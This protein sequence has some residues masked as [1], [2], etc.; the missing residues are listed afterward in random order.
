MSS[1][2]IAPLCYLLFAICYLI[3]FAGCAKIDKR[4]IFDRAGRKLIIDRPIN[5]IVS[6]AP[7]N[8][9]II[10]DLGLGHKLVAT[11][12]YS[13]NV[14]GIPGSIVLLDFSYP[15]A[16]VIISLQPDIIF[17][18]GHNTTV[19]GDDPFRLLRELGIP[20]AYIS[21]SN[22]IKGIYED[23]RFIADV[24]QVRQ[25]G[26][27]V[28][29]AMKTQVSGI[30]GRTAHIGPKKT[31]YFEVSAAPHMITFGKD[32]FI[33]NMISVAGGR[34]I[35][36]NEYWIVTPGAESII[37][38]NPDIILTNVDYIDDPIGEIKSRPGFGHI[39]AVI[40]NRVYQIDTDS[41]VRPSTRIIPALRQMAD[42]IYS[43]ES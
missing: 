22:S 42:A 37:N 3:V 21:M 10:V 12:S 6:T 1:R 39:N 30:T 17:A 20:I 16:E 5:R 26:E 4:E 43:G 27:A 38:R 13:S 7:A 29:N 36:A 34:N 11:D 35:F 14:T 2:K 25:E 33:D 41:S 15:D 32:S 18:S 40:N 31:V 23:I 28:I 19:S 24:L 8:T 9:E